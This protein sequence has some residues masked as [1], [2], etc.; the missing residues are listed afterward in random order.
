MWNEIITVPGCIC[1]YVLLVAYW[2]FEFHKVGKKLKEVEEELQK[3]SSNCEIF[4][5]KL[6]DRF[7]NNVKY[8]TWAIKDCN[9]KL[10]EY[11]K[12]IGALK[13]DM[14]KVITRTDSISKATAYWGT[15]PASLPLK[16]HKQLIKDVAQIKAELEAITAII[17]HG[18]EAPK[19]RKRKTYLDNPESE[20]EPKL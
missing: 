1:S 3:R 5:D 13:G 9:E 8:T 15:N 2:V 11:S 17:N 14:E 18:S 16:E 19:V 6:R 4:V 7:E 10:K 20:L 12:M